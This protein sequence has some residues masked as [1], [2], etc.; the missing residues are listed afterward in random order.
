MSGTARKRN[1]ALSR[2]DYGDQMRR[3]LICSCWQSN[4][5]QTQDRR[6]VTDVARP[7]PLLLTKNS[8]LDCRHIDEIKC[9]QSVLPAT[10]ASAIN[11]I[12]KISAIQLTLFVLSPKT[13]CCAA[14]IPAPLLVQV[15][16]CPKR[17][18]TQVLSKLFKNTLLKAY[19]LI[20]LLLQHLSVLQRAKARKSCV[21]LAL[22]I[23]VTF[24]PCLAER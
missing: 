16:M 19:L 18:D 12:I 8:P 22:G 6:P 4:D 17:I 3:Q 20:L 15:P 24:W 13:G 23:P 7:A 2:P 10:S 14:G 9:Y 5:M 11:S 1:W 21:V